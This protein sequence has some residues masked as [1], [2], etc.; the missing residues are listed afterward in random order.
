MFTLS[1]YWIINLIFFDF[2]CAC[3]LITTRS[4]YYL[5]VVMQ[6]VPASNFYF[7]NSFLTNSN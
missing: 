5:P 7:F 2:L 6:T 3:M 1:V 4:N